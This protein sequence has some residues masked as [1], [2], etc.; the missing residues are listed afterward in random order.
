[1]TASA[2][3]SHGNAAEKIL[4]AAAENDGTDLIVIATRGRTGWRNSLFG[5]VAERVV[6]LSPIP[7]LTVSGKP[8]A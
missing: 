7:V 2:I 6:R 8:T 1:M 5:S 3:V 4:D